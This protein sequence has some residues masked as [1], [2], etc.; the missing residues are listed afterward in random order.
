VPRGT[1]FTSRFDHDLLGGVVAL[2]GK[3]EAVPATA[4][5]DKLYRDFKPSANRPLDI[6]LV[7]YH[8]WANRGKSEMTVWMPLGR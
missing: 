5:V 6:K 7:P 3:A 8:A 2:E 1:S 4:W